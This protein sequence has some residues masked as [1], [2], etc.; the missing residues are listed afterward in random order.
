MHRSELPIPSPCTENWDTMTPHGKRLFCDKC[1]KHVQD[2]TRMSEREARATLEREGYGTTRG[3]ELC[4]RYLHDAYGNLVF[5]MVDPG[6]VAPSRLVRAK[7]VAAVAATAAAAAFVM[8]CGGAQTPPGGQMLGGAP[9]PLPSNEQ[10][11]GATPEVMGTVQMA[12]TAPAPTSPAPSG[13]SGA[14]PSKPR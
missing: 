9:P 13:S 7:R 5:Q 8:A 2:L 4:V 6:I 3:A 12:S 10:G 14:G 11:Q 1:N